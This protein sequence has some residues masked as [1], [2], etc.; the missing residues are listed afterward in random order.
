MKPWLRWTLLTCL[1]LALILL[2]FALWEAPINAWTARALTPAAGR[3]TLAAL[4]TL[5]LAV[6]VLLP[7][8]SSFVSAGAVS[9]LGAWQGGVTIALGMSLA[10]WL[11]YTLGRLGGEPLALR[12]A[13]PGELQRASRM[14]SRYGSWVLLVCRGVPVVAEAS[15]LL[16]G[17]TR[18]PAWRFAVVTGLGNIGL[19]CA[20]AAIGLLQLSGAAALAAP[21]AFGIAVPALALLLMRPLASD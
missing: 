14:M 9:L 2:P 1:V 3:A 19:A 16:A 13:G 5:L 20:Y 4:V 8:P 18:V 11:G 12:L 15:T 17:A 21:F 10:A 7:I 6:D